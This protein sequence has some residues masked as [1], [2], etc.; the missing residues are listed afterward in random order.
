MSSTRL[1][2]QPSPISLS[3]KAAS[4]VCIVENYWVTNSIS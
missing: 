2:C 4:E 3:A 1:G